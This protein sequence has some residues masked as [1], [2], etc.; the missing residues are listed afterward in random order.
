[1]ANTVSVIIPTKNRPI[2]LG[3]TVESLFQQSVLPIQLI[4]VD[5]SQTEESKERVEWLFAEASS[6]I[7]ET[8]QLFH[9]LD[10]AI[11]GLTVARNRGMERAQGD[12]CLFLD[13]DVVLEANFLEELLAVYERHP[14]ITGVSGIITNYRRPPLL[15]RLWHTVF[16]R[17]PFHDERQAIYRNVDSLRTTDLVRID[18]LG[19]GLMSFR[20]DAIRGCLFDENLCG[21]S[22]GEDVDFCVRLQ[23]TSLLAIAPRARLVHSQSQGGRLIDHH[24]RRDARAQHFLYRKNWDHRIENQLC[25]LWLNVGYAVLATLGCLRR[26]SMGPWRA[27]LMGVQEGEGI[28][29]QEPPFV[30]N[31]EPTDVD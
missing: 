14:Q 27:L 28:V 13:D 30:H 2:D 12:I 29:R 20:A 16:F 10:P 3:L 24:L 5:Q 31:A 21:V 7:R 17:G 23:P 19:G 18:R 26:F 6:A 15:S 22:D 9:I 1:M 8:V 4:V 11:S 25:F